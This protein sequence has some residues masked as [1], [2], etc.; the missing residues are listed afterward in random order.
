VAKRGKVQQR[1]GAKFEKQ[2]KEIIMISRKEQVVY[3]TYRDNLAQPSAF[4]PIQTVT[5]YGAY[6]RPI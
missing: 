5:T 4:K 3:P 2:Y 6:Q 1:R